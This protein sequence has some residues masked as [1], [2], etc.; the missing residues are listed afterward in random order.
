MEQSDWDS[1]KRLPPIGIVGLFTLLWV[2]SITELWI[3][4]NWI[5]VGAGVTLPLGW[6]DMN[7][8][9]LFVGCTG[10]GDPAEWG[11]RASK[12]GLREPRAGAA[13]TEGPKRAPVKWVR[14]PRGGP[15][16]EGPKRPLSR[17]PKRAGA[18]GG[19]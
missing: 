3:M 10:E 7:L 6:W 2:V 18:P 9:G 14:R 8:V 11:R 15:P 1:L 13:P 5:G 4:W 19:A 16:S 17:A 12:R